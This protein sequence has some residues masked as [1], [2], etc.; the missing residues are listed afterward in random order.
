MDL[1]GRL[2]ALHE[3][4]TGFNSQ[5]LHRY[6]LVLPP[7]KTDTRRKKQRENSSCNAGNHFKLLIYQDYT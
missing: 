7:V 1:R 5:H 4:G 3:Q 2:C 6:S